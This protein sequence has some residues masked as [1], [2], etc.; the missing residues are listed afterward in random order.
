M[1][2]FYFRDDPL[3]ELE[4]LYKQKMEEALHINPQKEPSVF[5]RNQ[6]ELA[7]LKKLIEEK[8]KEDDG[9]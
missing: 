5:L 1:L 9:E 7:A 8:K 4:K 2:D 6:E 3:E